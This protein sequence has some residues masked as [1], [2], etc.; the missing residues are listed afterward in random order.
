MT[1]PPGA[2]GCT[3]CVVNDLDLSVKISSGGLNHP[4]GLNYRDRL[5]TVERV[6]TS[7][8]Y[9]EQIDIT[10]E[11]KNFAYYDQ[12]FSLVITGYF[13]ED[14]LTKEPTRQNTRVHFLPLP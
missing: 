11:A 7:V 10:V 8:T 3:T 9:G 13:S 1:D 4:N 2:I 6:Q 12:K 14:E 5:D